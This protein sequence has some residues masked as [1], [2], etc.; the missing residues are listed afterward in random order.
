MGGTE[1][2]G[3][4][5]QILKSEGKLGQG[6]RALKGGGGVGTPLR[7]MY[8]KPYP[9]WGAARVGISPKNVLTFTSNLLA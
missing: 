4:E 8:Y 5:T 9:R 1:K 6:V 7:T 3:G 2:S